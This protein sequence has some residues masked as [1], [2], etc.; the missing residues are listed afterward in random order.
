VEN[1]QLG[2][3]L[4]YASPRGRAPVDAE[5]YLPRSWTG[6]RARCAWAD[7][8]GDV[9]FATRPTPAQA[10]LGF[11]AVLVYHN[12]LLRAHVVREPRYCF[13]LGLAGVR[14]SRYVAAR[15]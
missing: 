1:C 5:L 13:A 14:R 12:S 6:D 11:A 3:F 10:M 4:A 2:V 15:V 7:V 8:P 9:G